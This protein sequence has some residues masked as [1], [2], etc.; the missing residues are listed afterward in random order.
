VEADESFSKVSSTSIFSD[1]LRSELTTANLYLSLSLPPCPSLSLSLFLSLSP[2]LSLS[3][4]LSL[5]PSLP[6]GAHLSGSI[7]SFSFSTV[8][9]LSFLC[10]G[11]NICMRVG[12]R[13][14]MTEINIIGTVPI[15]VQMWPCL[16]FGAACACNCTFVCVRM[17]HGCS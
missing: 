17:G 10:G 12:G 1:V 6:A 15:L 2:S 13:L 14:K 11:R 4:A 5:S 7:I 3:H 16:F 9:L 8:F